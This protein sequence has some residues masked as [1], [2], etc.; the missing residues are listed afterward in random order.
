MKVYA[1]VFSNYDP[2]EVGGLYEAREDAEAEAE[3]LNAEMDWD[4]W[5]V[6]EWTV[7]PRV[8]RG[9]ADRLDEVMG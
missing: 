8:S 5:E 7:T 2:P 4:P 6:V 9:A 1:V 3:R